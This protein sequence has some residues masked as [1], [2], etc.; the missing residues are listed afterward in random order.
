MLFC[1]NILLTLKIGSVDIFHILPSCTESE[2][3]ECKV[4]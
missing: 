4:E 2:R 3:L 1:E